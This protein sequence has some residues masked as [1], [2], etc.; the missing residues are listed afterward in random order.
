MLLSVNDICLLSNI[1]L[2]L[3]S[4]AED[5]IVDNCI[6]NDNDSNKVVDSIYYQD[7]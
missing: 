7:S 4:A 2:L 6:S 3:V 1:Y 5:D